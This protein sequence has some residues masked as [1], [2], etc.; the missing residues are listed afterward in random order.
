LIGYIVGA[1][2]GGLLIS[3]TTSNMHDASLEAAMTGAFVTGP[4][5]AIVAGIVG[6]VRGR[7][8]SRQD[9]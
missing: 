7:K 9:P 5:A 4:A 2:G 1:F 8:R 3:A 6:F